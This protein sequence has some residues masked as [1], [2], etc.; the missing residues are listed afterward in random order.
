MDS[1]AILKKRRIVMHQPME[2]FALRPD[3]ASKSDQRVFHAIQRL[4]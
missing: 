4:Q 1:Q 2:C 3:D